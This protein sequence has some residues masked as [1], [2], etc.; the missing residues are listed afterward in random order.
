[1]EA[2]RT[3]K[4][5][6]FAA[7]REIG[8]VGTL[9]DISGAWYKAQ[10]RATRMAL[11]SNNAKGGRISVKTWCGKKLLPPSLSKRNVQRLTERGWRTTR[12]LFFR[13]KLRGTAKKIKRTRNGL[14]LFESV[15][16][17]SCSSVF[18]GFHFCK[19]FLLCAPP[20]CR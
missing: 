19:L 3:E 13:V 12:V 14:I 5:Y 1:V 11:L 16:F 9:T 6:A 20:K 7:G 15:N 17:I 8:V 2:R 18:F 10:K 4:S